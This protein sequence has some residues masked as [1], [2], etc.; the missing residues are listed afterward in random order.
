MVFVTSL[1]FGGGKL[2]RHGQ[3]RVSE[4]VE[5]CLRESLVVAVPS[6]VSQKS[7][8]KDV[9]HSH[10]TRF[11]FLFAVHLLGQRFEVARGIVPA[12]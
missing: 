12:L 6:A 5:R 11:A 3:G 4:Q 2:D 8:Y 7:S 9:L 1:T 10:I